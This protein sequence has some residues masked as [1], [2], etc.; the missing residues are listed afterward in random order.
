MMRVYDFYVYKRGGERFIVYG[1]FE[2]MVVMRVKLDGQLHPIELVRLHLSFSQLSF[3]PCFTMPVV[4]AYLS[5]LPSFLPSILPLRHSFIYV[6]PFFL[7]SV[8]AS[9][10]SLSSLHSRSATQCASGR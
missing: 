6:V 8:P 3:R 9:P 5:F 1:V 2:C 4:P 7:P 10:P